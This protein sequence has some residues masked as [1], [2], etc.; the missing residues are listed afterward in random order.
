MGGEENDPV[1]TEK[2]SD[3]ASGE[4]PED[5]RFSKR[6]KRFFTIFFCCILSLILA[7]VSALV[8]L[9]ILN[10]GEETGPDPNRFR[11]FG[12]KHSRDM[13]TGW[14]FDSNTET[15]NSTYSYYTS[16]D[17]VSEGEA[18]D[19]HCA[20]KCS[21]E[22]AFAGAW[23]TLLEECWCYQRPPDS[24]YCLEPCV[25]E[26]GIEFSTKKYKKFEYCE[27]SFCEL[28][29]DAEDYCRSKNFG[30]QACFGS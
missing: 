16:K 27:Q 3:S 9:V 21:F 28:F 18:T 30:W 6:E 13:S 20:R 10:G 17:L 29:D 2:S 4:N 25:A 14:L 22:N 1:A 19:R 12:F 7:A 15:A 8:W 23:N 24:H 26:Q 11:E 5:R